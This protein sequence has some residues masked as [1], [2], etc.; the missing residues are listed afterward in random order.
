MK[1]IKQIMQRLIQAYKE[2]NA[3]IKYKQVAISYTT[4]LS[5]EAWKYQITNLI[6]GC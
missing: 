4:P 2:Y 1:K 3:Y 5:F 6:H